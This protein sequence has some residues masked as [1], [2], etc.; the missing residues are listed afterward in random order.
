M[1][2]IMRDNTIAHVQDSDRVRIDLTAGWDSRAVLG[3][4]RSVVDES[5]IMAR[6]DG[7][8]G[9]QDVAVARLVAARSGIDHHTEEVRSPCLDDFDRHADLLSFH[10]NGDTNAMRAIAPL[11]SAKDCLLPRLQGAG[12]A[13]VRGYL[14]PPSPHLGGL[15]TPRMV[16]SWLRLWFSRLN[17][18]PWICDELQ[19]GV[20]ERLEG[21]VY[22][23]VQRTSN[24]HDLLDLMFLEERYAHW[25][26]MGSRFT[27]QEMWTPFRSPALVRRYWKMPPAA[28]LHCRVHRTLIRRHVPEAGNIPI[29]GTVLLPV[30]ESLPVGLQPLARTLTGWGFSIV[31]RARWVRRR[32]PQRM[33][34]SEAIAGPLGERFRDVLGS[35]S[36]IAAELLGSRNVHAMLDA[37]IARRT[38]HLQTLGQLMAMEH[39]RS[40]VRTAA[41]LASRHHDLVCRTAPPS[42]GH[43]ERVPGEIVVADEKWGGAISP[44]AGG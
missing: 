1:I 24:G 30:H 42:G 9:D 14:Y 26:A 20:V 7:E 37:H 16:V 4:L 33:L 43:P 22:R 19:R 28:G 25:G 35:P 34:R 18:I 11:P 38:W 13:L 8:P 6:T 17:T 36:S 12:G 32:R 15:F 44:R 29:N 39:W 2:E 3:L 27:W 23:N 21:A 40:Q 31:K 10:M 5:R 41:R